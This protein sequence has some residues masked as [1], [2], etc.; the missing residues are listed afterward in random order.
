MTQQSLAD[1]AVFV[2]AELAKITDDVTND[3]AD[4]HAIRRIK[5]MA[6]ARLDAALIEVEALLSLKVDVR[7]IV[8]DLTP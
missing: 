8:K 5:H 4:R 3:H 6:V 1:R 2:L 7:E